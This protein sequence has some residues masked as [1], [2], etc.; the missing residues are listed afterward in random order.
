M[1][2]E[3]KA[4]KPGAR[5]AA[6]RDWDDI[7]AMR[8][9][10]EAAEPAEREEEGRAP[11]PAAQPKQTVSE[12]GPVAVLEE[13]KAQGIAGAIV[14]AD[15]VLIHSTMAMT[16]AGAGFLASVANTADALMK[17]ALDSPRETEITFGELILVLMPIGNY[18]FCGA[19]KSRDQKKAVREFADKA[20]KML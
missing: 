6:E 7:S 5:K 16:D 3:D 20:R 9:T 1:D 11:P 13:M 15:G 18:I 12:A 2:G 4:Q 19:V 8:R 10:A 14:R 17:R